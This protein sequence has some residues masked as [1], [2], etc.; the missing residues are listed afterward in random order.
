MKYLDSHNHMY[1]RCLFLFFFFFTCR[2]HIFMGKSAKLHTNII[3]KFSNLKETCY[4]HAFIQIFKAYQRLFLLITVTFI[5]NL[6]D[7]HVLNMVGVHNK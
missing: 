4:Q 7:I 3:L 2:S 1:C 5:F 6:I